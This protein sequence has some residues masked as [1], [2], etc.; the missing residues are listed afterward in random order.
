MKRV[1]TAVLAGA[2]VATLAYASA[3]ALTVDSN[4]LQAGYD[5]VACDADGVTVNWGLE[6]DDNSVR[7]V[8]VG[9]IHSDCN[10]AKLF[11]AVN[12]ERVDADGFEITTA[13]HSV[14]FE[15]PYPTPES[16]HNVKVWI[17]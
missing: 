3:S 13:T 15:A 10:G 7:S 11:V 1:T 9:D 4:P 2:T 16:I 5:T 6:T 8:K 17:G 14:P 12:G